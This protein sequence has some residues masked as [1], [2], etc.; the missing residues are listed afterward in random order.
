[1]NLNLSYQC[2]WW[3]LSADKDDRDCWCGANPYLLTFRQTDLQQNSTC[4][5]VRWRGTQKR[6]RV[7]ICFHVSC[8]VTLLR[9]S[10]CGSFALS[11]PPRWPNLSFP[12]WRWS[13]VSDVSSRMFECVVMYSHLHLNFLWWAVVSSWVSVLQ[14]S[15]EEALNRAFKGDQEDGE[16]NIIQEL[17]RAIVEEVKRMSGNDSCCDCGAAG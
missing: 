12:G 13:W 1:M 10:V 6:R 3:M 2:V 4:S 9:L 11:P 17:T 8:Q 16:N 15:K 7:L 14:N 5:R